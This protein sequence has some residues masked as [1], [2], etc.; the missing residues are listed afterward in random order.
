MALITGERGRRLES[1]VRWLEFMHRQTGE[2]YSAT[3]EVGDKTFVLFLPAGQYDITRVQ[4]SERP[5]VNRSALV[6]F[7]HRREVNDLGW[8]PAF[9]SRFAAV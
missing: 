2:R 5:L 3:L 1:E 4:I 8:Q 9:W 6:F 7:F